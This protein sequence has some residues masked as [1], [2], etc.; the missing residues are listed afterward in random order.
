M[1][2]VAECKLIIVRVY[3]LEFPLFLTGNEMLFLNKYLFGH[4]RNKH[5]ARAETD[6]HNTRR[7]LL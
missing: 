3:L 5:C 7:T 4:V 2:M 6:L 1:H